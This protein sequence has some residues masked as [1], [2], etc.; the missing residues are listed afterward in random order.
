VYKKIFS[1]E[2]P[3][4]NLYLSPYINQH[5]RWF[6]TAYNPTFNQTPHNMIALLARMDYHAHGNTKIFPSFTG[7]YFQAALQSILMS[8]ESNLKGAMFALPGKSSSTTDA[9][10]SYTTSRLT[11]DHNEDLEAILKDFASIHFGDRVAEQMAEIYL[12]SAVAYK[13]GIYIEPATFGTFN[14]LL[15][16]RLT[17]FPAQGFPEID[18]GKEHMA[19]LRSLYYKC[20]PWIKETIIYLDHG[21]ATA[22]S[23]LAKYA[24]VKGKIKAKAKSTGKADRRSSASWRRS[25]YRLTAGGAEETDNQLKLMRNLIKTN[26][27]YV[28]GFLSYFKFEEDPSAENR[29]ELERNFIDL[30]NAIIQFK[31]SPGFVY[32]LFGIDQLVKNIDL[33]LKDH[34][35]AKERINNAPSTE[36]IK[37]TIIAQQKKYKDVLKKHNKKAI[38]FLHWEG[39]VDGRDVLEIKGDKMSIKHLRWDNISHLEHTFYKKLP[40]KSVTVIPDDLYSRPIHPFIMEQPNARNNYTAR[41][42]L[43]DEPGGRDWVKFDLYYITENPVKL[44]LDIKW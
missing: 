15:H 9:I 3:T 28:K 44:G 41:I 18:F 16:L 25:T 36:E 31:K 17:T 4:K 29:H 32:K 38:K 13:Y 20:K 10:M 39:K 5:D 43:F 7:A 40:D 34:R 21:L 27:L 11:W 1:D 6:F 23:M 12:L 26:N 14:T 33:I 30:K 2:V 42:Y 22:D 35:V 8:Q 19:F 24:K 37:N